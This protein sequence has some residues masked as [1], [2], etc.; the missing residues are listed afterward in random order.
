GRR[1][2]G[3]LRLHHL[4]AHGGVGGSHGTPG[5]GQAGRWPRIRA[6][7]APDARTSADLVQGQ[8]HRAA[9]KIRSSR[10][11]RRGTVLTTRG[12]E[13]SRARALGYRL[14]ASEPQVAYAGRREVGRFYCANRSHRG[15]ATRAV[16]R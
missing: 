11:P 6:V 1:A 12:G 5:G 13:L 15:A 9:V 4:A 16:G 8:R 2:A 3:A 14:A 7:P 10:L